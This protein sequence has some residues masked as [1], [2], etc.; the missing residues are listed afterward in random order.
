MHVCVYVCAH[1][2]PLRVLG[3]QLAVCA[4]DCMVPVR[5]SVSSEVSSE[6]GVHGG[7]LYCVLDLLCVCVRVME[8]L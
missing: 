1:V 3:V 8:D 4:C 6:V 2:P 7:G 5:E